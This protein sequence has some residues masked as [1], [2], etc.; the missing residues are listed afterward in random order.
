MNSDRRGT[1]TG[2]DSFRRWQWQSDLRTVLEDLQAKA[3]GKARLSPCGKLIAQLHSH[4]ICIAHSFSAILWFPEQTLPFEYQISPCFS[5]TCSCESTAMN[6]FV[7]C[8]CTGM[9]PWWDLI[10]QL[11]LDQPWGMYGPVW[12][13]RVNTEMMGLPWGVVEP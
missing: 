5:R 3:L 12:R 2:F 7:Q 8:S 4:G 9:T 13:M 6:T 10:Y 1:L 11:P